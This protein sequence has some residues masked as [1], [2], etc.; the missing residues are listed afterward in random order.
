VFRVVVAGVS[1]PSLEPERDV[2]ERIGA[3]VAVASDDAE[4]LALAR[5]ADALLTDYFPVA[6]DVVAEL[7]RCRVVCQYGVG[8]DGIDIDAATAA[9]ILVTHTPAYCVDELADHALALLL[10]VARKVTL[11]DR[12]VREGAWDYNVG[13]PMRSLRG[14]TLGLVGFGRTARALAERVAP[15]GLRALAHDP[16]V[17]AET[18]AAA[19]AEPA[20]LA[21]VLAE[22]HIVSLHVPL[23]SET[24]GLLGAAELAAMKP[25]SIVVNTARGG[26]VDERALAAALREGRLAGA[27]LDVLATEPPARDNPLLALENVVLTPHAAFL[28]VES[29]MRVQRQAAEE[30]AR[31]L[32]G[33]R[34][35]HAVNMAALEGAKQNTRVGAVLP[36][37]LPK[38]P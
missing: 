19:G 11:Y 31:V 30:V 34:P 10:A 26:L 18:I 22:S 13:P 2:L 35:R 33:E 32:T 28:S 14:R 20:T 27:G 29:L 8:L 21:R 4:A 7:R 9:G 24:R 6:A 25:G 1:F 5:E 38:T 37:G 3:E 15:L 36:D 12:S 16:L 23:T 17:A